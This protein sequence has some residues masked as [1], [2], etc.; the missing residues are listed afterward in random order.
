MFIACDESVN[1]RDQGPKI[2]FQVT[3]A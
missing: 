3:N 1:L 2:S